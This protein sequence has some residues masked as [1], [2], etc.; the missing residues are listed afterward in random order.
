MVE[1]F[2]PFIKTQKLFHEKEPV[3]LAVSGGIDSVV[4]THLFHQCNFQFGIA[5]MNFQL[6]DE[7]SMSDERFVES[8]AKQLEVPFFIT[9]VNT[10]E[11][12]AT[13]KSSI[14]MAARELRYDW[15]EKIRKEKGY[16]FIAT[17]HHQNDSIETVL[18]NMF[19]GTGIH[20]LHGIMPKKNKIVRPLLPFFKT[21]IVAFAEKEN[22]SFRHDQSNLK[23]DY[24]RNKIRLRIIPEIEKVYPSFQHVFSENIAKWQDAER[25]YEQQV[26]LLKKKLVE[27]KVEETF[28]SISKISQ[29]GSSK[30]IL[31]E[32]LKDFN[33]TPEQAGII[34]SCF[35]S[36]PGKIFYSATHRL[37]KD[38]KQ[39]ILSKISTENISEMLISGDERSISIS[40]IHI[41]I[42]IK[43]DGEFIIPKNSLVSCLDYDKL[44]FPLLLRKWRKGD[45]FYPL[46]MKKKKKK[47][48]DYLID[49]KIPLSE[50][51]NT[52]LIESGK[53]I[54]CILGERIDDRLKIT[55]STKKIMILRKD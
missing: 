26:A 15:L 1:K 52:W 4:M 40:S 7:D 10:A 24:D 8:L 48:S 23:A 19:R 14:Q 53:R 3:L 18:L 31:Y 27:E 49:R 47:V 12:A 16:H 55:P 39:L 21:E 11:Y 34:H 2:I 37:V 30:T 33:F 38:R 5:H 45:Y 54:A 41:K 22:I 9:H 32:I 51:E 25:L 43:E 36:I 6:R 17:A 20:G 29:L 46:G 13:T 50:K 42:E 35:N 28:I 44:E